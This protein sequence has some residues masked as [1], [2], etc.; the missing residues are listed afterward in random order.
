MGRA[1]GDRGRCIVHAITSTIAANDRR[2]AAT[3]RAPITVP[4]ALQVSHR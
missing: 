1:A 4:A 3:I 2:V